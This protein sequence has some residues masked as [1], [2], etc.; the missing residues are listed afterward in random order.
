MKEVINRLLLIIVIILVV[1]LGYR[2]LKPLNTVMAPVASTIELKS[3]S[4]VDSKEK[5][6]SVIKEYLME[7]PQIIIESI[8]QLQKRKMQENEEKVSNYIKEKKAVIEDSTYSPIMGNEKGEIIIVSFYDYNCSYCKKGNEYLEQLVKAD[9]GVKIVLKPFPILGESSIYAAKVA[10]AI[11]K[12]APSK[13]LTIHDGLIQMKPITKEAV[14]SLITANQL[15]YKLIE[16]EMD[17]KEIQD[18]LNKNFE[19]ADNLKIRGVPASI[20]NEKII[21]G[22]V[23]LNQFQQ[24]IAGIRENNKTPN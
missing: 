15:D 9:Q 6:Q 19:M 8:E 2:M 12:I 4:E 11:N 24:I 7:N 10:L 22:L 1:F 17:K 16:E 13:F 21:P 14:E 5:V 18:M 3:L 20:I 23:D